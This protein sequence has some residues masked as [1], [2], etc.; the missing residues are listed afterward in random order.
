MFLSIN[1]SK[2]FFVGLVTL[3]GLFVVALNTNIV[4]YAN[5]LS[6]NQMANIT[7]VCNSDVPDSL[8]ECAFQ[9]PTSITGIPS[10]LKLG[11]GTD[12]DP[13]GLCTLGTK[14]I[15][16]VG[17]PVGRIKN[18]Q[19]YASLG[20]TQ[21][22]KTLGSVE[23]QV[24]FEQTDETVESENTTVQLF[25]TSSGETNNTNINTNPSNQTTITPT[26]NSTNNN[27][28][29]IRSGGAAIGVT[30]FVLVSAVCVVLNFKSQK[31][32]KKSKIKIN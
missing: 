7:V 21:I 18:T 22:I 29:L 19:I 1:K 27:I 3:F 14:T 6:L 15:S 9:K 12:V 11:I 24:T 26:N 5:E 8:T 25:L 20:T 32:I 16:C 30:L 31:G 28:V 4:L 13:E 17:I 10:N 23:P 2:F